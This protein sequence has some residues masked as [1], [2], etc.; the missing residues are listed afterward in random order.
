MKIK[1]KKIW[2]KLGYILPKRLPEMFYICF[3]G[4]KDYVHASRTLSQGLLSRYYEKHCLISKYNRKLIG[5]EC[6]V[7]LDEG[8]GDPLNFYGKMFVWIFDSE[9]KAIKKYKASK[10]NKNNSKLSKPVKCLIVDSFT[11]KTEP[12]YYSF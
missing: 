8:N 10:N 2:N 3:E 12:S 7:L 4:N 5:Q 1:L 11:I 9:E 6:W